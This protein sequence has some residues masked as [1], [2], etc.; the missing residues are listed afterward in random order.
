MLVLIANW[1]SVSLSWDHKLM[2]ERDCRSVSDQNITIE[3][4]GGHFL[5][6]NQNLELSS[7]PEHLPLW[8]VLRYLSKPF[9]LLP[10]IISK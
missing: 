9:C 10:F 2:P 6:Q 1:E 4:Q 5:I 8:A 7:F 3:R